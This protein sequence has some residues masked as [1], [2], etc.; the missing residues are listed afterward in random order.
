VAAAL[1]VP[2]DSV[3]PMTTPPPV[4]LGTATVLVLAGPDLA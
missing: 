2:V 1:G 4:T 3:Q